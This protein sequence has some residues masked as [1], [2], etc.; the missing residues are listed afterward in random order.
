MQRYDVMDGT[1]DT[2]QKNDPV[3]KTGSALPAERPGFEPGDRFVTG[4]MIS[5]HAH[6][7]TL[8]SLPCPGCGAEG[9]GFEPPVALATTVFKTV[10][11]DHSANPPWPP[12]GVGLPR[13]REDCS[14]GLPGHK[15]DATT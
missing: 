13:G 5:N 8:P 15:S 2:P 12:V 4:H 6:S 7:A 3:V 14:P 11:F 1:N 9:E 10:A